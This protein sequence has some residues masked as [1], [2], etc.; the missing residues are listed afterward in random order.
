MHL[1]GPSMAM[2]Q[3]STHLQAEKHDTIT[4]LHHAGHLLLTSGLLILVPFKSQLSF[5]NIRESRLSAFHSARL[6]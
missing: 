3:I 1:G 4:L 6:L 2:M 5:Q